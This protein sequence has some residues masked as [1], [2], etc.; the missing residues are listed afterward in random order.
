MLKSYY[1]NLCI[2]VLAALT[3]WFS[4]TP[5][6]VEIA[7]L[8][9]PELT[10]SL[11]QRLKPLIDAHKGEVAVAVK[12]LIT[13]ETFQHRADVPMPTASLVKFPVMIEV[14]RQA[15]AGLIDLDT[16]IRL[17]ERDKVPGSGILTTHFSDGL[18][19]SLRDCV[20]LM[21]AFSDNTATN[22][23][24]DR[25]GIASTGETMRELGFTNTAIHSK[26]FRRQTSIAPERSEKFGLGSTTANEM[27]GLLE[28][29]ATNR[30]VSESASV[31]MREH[32]NKC[33]DNDKM[34]R[35][36]PVGV[37]VAH[38]TGSVDN[39]RTAA[40]LIETSSGTLAI[41]VLTNKNADERWVADNAGNRLCA[42][43]ALQAFE[44]A[45]KLGNN[46]AAKPDDQSR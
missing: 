2:I 5:A 11:E 17:S 22:L 3:A 21:I 39:V 40:G 20:R 42:E 45:Q 18:T 33:D 37:V 8:A 24:L 30:L 44:H 36:L 9:P 4:R 46:R 23:V 28:M 26:V 6:P 27:I 1:F 14:Y 15:H 19:L 16:M 25:I 7:R 35:L 34:P 38:K 13:G 31:A 41:C 29:L 10:Q 43:I 32:L 12:H